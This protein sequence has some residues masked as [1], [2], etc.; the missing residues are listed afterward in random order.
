M[1]NVVC[2]VISDCEGRLLACRRSSEQSQPGKWE[3]PGGK[4]EVGEDAEDALVREI[5]EELGCA[6]QVNSS[7]PVVEH[8]YPEFS[9]RLIPYFCQLEDGEIPQI[10]EHAEMR[11]V[12]LTECS[13]LDWAEADIPIWLA[14]LS[15]IERGVTARGYDW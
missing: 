8:R 4:I 5:S 6:I 9:I 2:A 1:I 3:F 13:G 15:D 11:W 10:M 14:L 12:T 7:L